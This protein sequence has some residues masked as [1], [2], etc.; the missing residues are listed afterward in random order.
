M[1][2]QVIVISG[3]PGTGKSTLAEKLAKEPGYSRLILSKYYAMISRRYNKTKQCYDIDMRRFTALVE[4]IKRDKK[5]DEEIKHKKL[6]GEIK[7]KE[8]NKK[9]EKIII[10]SHIAHL[11]PKKLVDLC[12]VLICS[13]L[14]KLQKRLE[15][16]KYSKKKIRENMDAEIFQVCLTEAKEKGHK[17]IVFDT[18]K[19]SLREMIEKV[20]MLER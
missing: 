16:R 6:N 18:A 14:K 9:I 12:I 17:I 13:D 15:Q 5:R 11:L 8:S 4:K 1:T 19:I 2:C 10:D 7:K 3:T 20:K